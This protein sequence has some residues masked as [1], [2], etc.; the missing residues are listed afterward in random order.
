MNIKKSFPEIPVVF[1]GD[2]SLEEKEP[3]LEI[4]IEKDE[5]YFE[6]PFYNRWSFS[7]LSDGFII[8]KR[9][10]WDMGTFHGDNV[11]EVLEQLKVYYK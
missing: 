10:T 8:G 3:I 1:K 6:M 7:K 2:W 4:I 9:L 5:E 11:S